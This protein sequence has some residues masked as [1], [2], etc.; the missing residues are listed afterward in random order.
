MGSCEI[1]ITG[2]FKEQV[3]HLAGMNKVYLFLP[4]H[5][6]LDFIS[7]IIA[8]Q[9]RR[10]Q[11]CRTYYGYSICFHAKCITRTRET[12]ELPIGHYEGTNLGC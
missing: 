8:T 11:F 10:I 7:M 12:P 3:E 2:N 6:E 1:P 9:R 5:W 4:Q